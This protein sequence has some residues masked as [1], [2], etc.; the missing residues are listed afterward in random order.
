MTSGGRAAKRGIPA[1]VKFMGKGVIEGFFSSNH[2]PHV[3]IYYLKNANYQGF[4]PNLTI[5]C[6]AMIA[7]GRRKFL[8]NLS[9]D[10]E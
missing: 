1:S 10:D 4:C 7:Q 5:K 6:C 8:P 9:I 3:R 2:F